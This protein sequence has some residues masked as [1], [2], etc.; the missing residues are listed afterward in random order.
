MTD[1]TSAAANDRRPS[2]AP[3]ELD[4]IDRSILRILRA[5]ARIPNNQLAERVGIA[6]STCVARVRSL[7]TRGVITG[8][9]ANVDPSSVGLSLQALISVTIRAGAR[10]LMVELGQEIRQFPEVVQLY[11]LGGAE[12]FIIHVAVRDSAAVR[13]FVLDNL[14]AHPAVASTRTSLVFDHDYSGVSIAP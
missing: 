12:D 10:N 6:P 7:V 11:F 4:E 1:P 9:T 13:D 3:A 2:Q 8:F 14:S 5:N